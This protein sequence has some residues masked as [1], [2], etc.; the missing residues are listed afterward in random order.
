M[1]LG[2]RYLELVLRYAKVAPEDDV[3]SY[4]GP[5]DLQERVEKEDVPTPTE[6]AEEA[7]SLAGR[8]VDDPD[9]ARRRWLAAQLAGIEAACRKLAG[10]SIPFPELVRRCYDV[11]PQLVPDEVF[12]E[13]HAELDRALEGSGDI[14]ARA[15]AW[16][17]TQVVPPDRVAAA[18]EELTGHLHDWARDAIGL[19]DDER[20]S[21]STTSGERWL[22]FAEYEGDL[23]T[24]IVLNTDIPMWSY[25]LAEFV[26]HEIYPGHHTE[27]VVKEV[28]L[29][30]RGY[31]ELAVFAAPAQKAFLTEGIADAGF[32]A[33]FGAEP[34][35]A[36]AELV[37]PLGIPY[38]AETATVIRRAKHTLEHLGVNARILLDEGRMAIDD[39]RPYLR[40]WMLESDDYVDRLARNVEDFPWHPYT[41][42]NTLARPICGRWVDRDPARLRRLL[43]EQLTT[44][45]LVA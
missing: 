13:A 31:L 1:T 17:D 24:R 41:V 4:T 10:E 22:G 9:D 11:E 3:D 6:V 29:I 37:R 18:L 2:E 45:D 34:D 12:A 36:A 27:N 26:T 38:D 16:L 35:T 44:A 20:V 43:A 19:P 39:V 23:R 14:R 32:E 21:L 25:R 42:S 30:R 15:L 8:V 5:P 33:A 40:R 7:R 28:E